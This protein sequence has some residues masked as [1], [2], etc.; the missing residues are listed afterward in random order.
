[1]FVLKMD[2]RGQADEEVGRVWRAPLRAAMVTLRMKEDLS[3]Y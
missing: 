2:H 1:M 3:G